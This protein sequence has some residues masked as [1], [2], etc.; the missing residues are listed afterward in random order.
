[1]IVSPSALA[2][3]DVG[4]L[5]AVIVVGAC[6]VAIAML[7]IAPGPAELMALTR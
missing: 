3:S 2:V 1:M 7:E 5:G 4:A 6:V